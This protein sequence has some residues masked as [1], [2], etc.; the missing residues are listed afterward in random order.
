MTIVLTR[1]PAKTLLLSWPHPLTLP[2]AVLLA[3]LLHP[4][5]A[6]LGEGIKLLY[7]MSEEAQRQLA[8]LEQLLRE[9]PLV[10]LLAVFALLPAVC[11]ELAFRGFILSGLSHSGHK[12]AAIAGSSLFFGVTHG[13]MQQSLAACLVG[14][15]IGY[16]AVQSGSL[17]PGILFHATHNSLALVAGRLIGQGPGGQWPYHPVIALAAG[18]LAL[19]VLFWFGRL[20][21]K[22]RRNQAGRAAIGHQPA[23]V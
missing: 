5:V 12:W 14:A 18:A 8:P 6:W 10:P 17:F 2:A 21:D 15:V 3:A 1:R 9:A 13:L 7:P 11:E 23:R 22:V 4:A 19:G 16:L 20:P